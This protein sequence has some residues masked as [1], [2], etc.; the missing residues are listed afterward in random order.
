MEQKPERLD[1]HFHLPAA[2][3][4]KVMAAVVCFWAALR[5]WPEF[6]FLQR[7]GGADRAA[8][9]AASLG[10]PARGR[11]RVSRPLTAWG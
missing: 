3:I 11:R 1:I 7:P 5:L 9:R 8:G 10:A 6:V 2:T 4:I